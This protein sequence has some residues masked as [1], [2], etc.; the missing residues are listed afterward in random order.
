M[1]KRENDTRPSAESVRF[2]ET[3]ATGLSERERKKKKLTDFPGS[4][5]VA[6]PNFQPGPGKKLPWE[7]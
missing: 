4:A 3:S 7:K 6:R 2:L 5:E 1:E